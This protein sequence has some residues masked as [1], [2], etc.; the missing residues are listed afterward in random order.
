MS[1]N[2][3]ETMQL[4]VDKFDMPD[5][6]TIV[7]FYRVNMS[8][9]TIF[10][11]FQMNITLRVCSLGIY[12]AINEVWLCTRT[13]NRPTS[14]WISVKHNDNSSS[15]VVVHPFCPFDYCKPERFDLNTQMSNAHFIVLASSVELVKR[16][17]VM[18]LELP[19]A[20][21]AQVCGLC[22]GFQSLP[23]PG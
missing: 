19:D 7:I 5:S 1:A 10:L 11:D 16:T 9:H 18:H 15:D 12:R 13:V 8:M 3:F 21:S 4:L 22:F 23:Y 6:K 14:F 2:R 20:G 17:L